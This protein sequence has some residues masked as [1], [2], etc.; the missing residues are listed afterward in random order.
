MLIAFIRVTFI[1]NMVQFNITTDD[2][3][4]NEMKFMFQII[5]KEKT[6]L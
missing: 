1:F 6:Y 5:T 2:I 4:H 3:G